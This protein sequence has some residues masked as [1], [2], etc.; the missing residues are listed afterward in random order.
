MRLLHRIIATSLA[1]CLA[2]LLTTGAQAQDFKKIPIFVSILPQVFFVE[3]IGGDRVQVDV[4]V[5]PG[6]SPHTYAPTPKQMGKLSEAK[7]YFRIGVTFEN[8]FVPKLESTMPGLRIV[9]TRQGITLEKM[10]AHQEEAEEPGH[11]HGEELDTHIWLDPLLVKKQAE[12]IRD[13]LAQIDPAGRPL[14]EKNHAAFAAELDALHARLSR[15]MAPL[16]GKSFFVYHP[17]FGYFA[18]RYGLQQIAVET[19]GKSPSARHLGKL[20][21]LAKQQGVRVLFVQ[22]QFS[23]KSALTVARAINGAV[24]PLDDLAKD[25]FNNMTAIAE[26]V[27]K[28]VK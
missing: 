12:I 21:D 16:Q 11:I 26:E 22:P 23:Q 19:G 2:L 1:L 10:A 17:A 25:Y 24:V 4:L 18:K 7:V 8:A 14:Y 9:D 20:I 13:T 6:Q 27:E 3:R 5:Q 15:A 28:A